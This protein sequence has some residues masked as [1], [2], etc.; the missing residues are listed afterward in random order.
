VEFKFIRFRC[1]LHHA[2]SSLSLFNF[3]IDINLSVG[4]LFFQSVAAGG[5]VIRRS[6][7]MVSLL[8]YKIVSLIPV[9]PLNVC[10]ICVTSYFRMVV[11]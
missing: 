1:F 4:N 2:F 7:T 5:V 9:L 11:V 10:V 3:S 8:L 6:G